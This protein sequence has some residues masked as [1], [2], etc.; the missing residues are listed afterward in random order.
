MNRLLFPV[1]VTPVVLTEGD[2][3]VAHDGDK[4]ELHTVSAS[5]A[6]LPGTRDVMTVW[7]S[8]E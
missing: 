5:P 4:A 8:H 3:S 7:P 1:V 6:L 2:T